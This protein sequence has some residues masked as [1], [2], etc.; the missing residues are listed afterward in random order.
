MKLGFS[1]QI[2]EK[3]T[4]RKFHENPSGGFRAFSRG[5]TDGHGE[6]GE[7]KLTQ[8]VGKL[9]FRISGSLGGGP[10]SRHG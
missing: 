8:N 2:F 10:G 7:N 1:G 9:L 3:S 5:Q 4:D 6:N